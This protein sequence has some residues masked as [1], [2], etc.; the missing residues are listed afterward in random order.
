MEEVAFAMSL[1][2]L[3]GRILEGG[4]GDEEHSDREEKRHIMKTEL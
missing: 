4:N 1:E 3:T 2:E